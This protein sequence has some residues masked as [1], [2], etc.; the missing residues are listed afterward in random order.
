MPY[1]TDDKNGDISEQ[2]TDR[3]DRRVNRERR[4]VIRKSYI[5]GEH[6]DF[7]PRRMSDFSEIMLDDNHRGKVQ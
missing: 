7:I 1:S 5:N 4:G 2:S 6:R 3:P